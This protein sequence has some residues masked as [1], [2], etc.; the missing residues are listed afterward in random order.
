MTTNRREP[1]LEAGED[2]FLRRGFPAVGL[3][4]ILTTVAS[5]KGAFYH[6]F[7]SKAAFAVAVLDAH[8]T[9]RTEEMQSIFG[10][11]PD[12]AGILRW[13]DADLAAMEEADFVPRCLARRLAA[14]LGAG[15][16]AAPVRT[17]LESLTTSLAE[18]LAAAQAA[19]AVYADF[20]PRAA[21]HHLLDLWHGA[22]TSAAVEGD[23]AAL[24]AA[25]DH[26]AVWL[27]P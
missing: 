24:R 9:R 15:M 26:F 20:D 21:A 1:M 23:P 12:L 18:A 3:R 11:A 8:L 27:K 25:L 17:A 13:F 19:G 5:S 16:P 14:D 7:P 6:F 2:L 22:A 4:D 10:E